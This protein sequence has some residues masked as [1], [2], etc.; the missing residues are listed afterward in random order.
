MVILKGLNGYLHMILKCKVK[1]TPYPVLLVLLL[2]CKESIIR[3]NNS[4]KPAYGKVI[5]LVGK[6]A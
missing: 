2:K 5:K 4:K 1:N 6:K 3:Y